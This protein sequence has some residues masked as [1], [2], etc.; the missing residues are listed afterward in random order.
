MINYTI[1]AI[2]F[3]HG[4]IH[5][6]GYSKSFHYSEL[7]NITKPISKPVGVIWISACLLFITTA[8]LFL[9]K[10]DYWKIAGVI[11]VILSQ[12]VIIISW[13]DA[14][15]GTIANLLILSFIIWKVFIE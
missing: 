2:I 6:M 5:L 15:Y 12:I 7:K 11:S 8:V 10:Q 9:I 14:K 13:K 4:L 1:A 3:I